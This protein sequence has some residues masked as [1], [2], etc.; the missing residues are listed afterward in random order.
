[1]ATFS[2]QN[3]NVSTFTPQERGFGDITWNEADFSWDEANGTWDDP[4][5]SWHNSSKNSSV[6]TNLSKN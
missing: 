3:K 4:R 6:M 5:D 1:M 2:N